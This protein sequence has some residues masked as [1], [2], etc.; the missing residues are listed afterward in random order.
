[1]N[2]YITSGGGDNKMKQI[3]RILALLFVLIFSW[4]C[5]T[6]GITTYALNADIA[7]GYHV[8]ISQNILYYNYTENPDSDLGQMKIKI[9][10]N[11]IYIGDEKGIYDFEY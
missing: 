4:V 9:Y 6:N 11:M 7:M 3:K 5:N 2:S 10:E 1:M 8:M